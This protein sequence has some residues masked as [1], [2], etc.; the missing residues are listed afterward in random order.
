MQYFV[1]M[2]MTIFA[3]LVA[4][5]ATGGPARTSSQHPLAIHSEDVATL[6]KKCVIRRDWATDFHGNPYV[7]KTRICG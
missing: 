2:A 5:T 1:M 7:R 3:F 4:A 6:D